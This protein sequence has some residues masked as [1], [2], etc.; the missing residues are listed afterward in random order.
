MRKQTALAIAGIAFGLLVAWA[1]WQGTGDGARAQR[2]AEAQ[3]AAE[4]AAGRVAEEEAARAE[5]EAEAERFARTLSERTERERRI[6]EEKRRRAEEEALR[7]S[8][9]R[10]A[11]GSGP[12]EEAGVDEGRLDDEALD[13]EEEETTPATFEE[14][15]ERAAD[16]AEDLGLPTE[17][18]TRAA[19]LQFIAWCRSGGCD[20]VPERVIQMKM[21]SALTAL[22]SA[23][24]EVL[25]RILPGDLQKYADCDVCRTS[26]VPL[27]TFRQ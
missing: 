9:G 12:L 24:D 10:S 16:N 8:T 19:A 6:A 4:R 1:V 7:G 2:E 27:P 18:G 17:G 13:E 15:L 3:A 14:N 11:G 22:A 26:P 5:R 25:A 20:G 21:D 23:P